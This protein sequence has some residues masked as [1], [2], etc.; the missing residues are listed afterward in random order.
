MSNP[1]DYVFGDALPEP[2]TVMTVADGVRWVRMPLPFAL[3]HVNL[4]LI[5]DGD[6]W[7]LIDC[8]I[9][10]DRTRDLWT[11]ILEN[12]LDGRPIT[13]IVVTHYHPD[14]MGSAGWLMERTPAQLWMTR[15]E[16]L[17][18]RAIR[19]DDTEELLDGIVGFYRRTGL[20][21]TDVAD[22]RTLGNSY[23][24]MVSPIPLTF[25]RLAPDTVLE[26]GGRKWVVVIAS[27][28]SPEHACLYC[29]EAGLM[30]G[31]DFLL[32][33]ISPNISVWWNEPDG[34]PLQDYLRFLDSLDPIADDT[35]VLPSHDRPF[36]GLKPRAVDL[37]AHHDQ[38][39]DL[40]AQV[41]R[42]PSTAIDVMN[43]MF[44]RK[45]DAHQTRFAVGESL[46]HLN[47]LID[48]GRLAR[49]LGDDGA[50]RYLAT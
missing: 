50:W 1:I 26:I 24:R 37:S 23:R 8:G 34:N 19:L 22:M 21:E 31:G 35:L 39:L 41:C 48:Q 16:W 12:Q 20:S 7:V 32:P 49:H 4:Y 30:L 45:M 18:A 11:A 13:Q 17:S 9:A 10:D 28:H 3:N 44:Q 46:A 5:D 27:G 43:A 36:R 42:T 15:S 6:G 25:N 38:R 29:P 14:H 40:A 47:F 33:R 2:G